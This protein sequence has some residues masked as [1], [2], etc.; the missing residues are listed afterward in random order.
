MFNQS[1]SVL[2]F[3][4]KNNNLNPKYE[5]NTKNAM[6]IKGTDFLQGKSKSCHKKKVMGIKSCLR[7]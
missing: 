2:Q 5:L 1:V 3:Y 6:Q 4:F 7:F